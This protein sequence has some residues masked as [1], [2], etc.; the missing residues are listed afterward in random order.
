MTPEEIRA[1]FAEIKEKNSDVVIEAVST[2]EWPSLNGHLYVRSLTLGQREDFLLT[3]QEPDGAG[4]DGKSN[5]KSTIRVH[6]GGHNA[7]L[8]AWTLCNKAGD[9]I[10]SGKTEEVD[11]LQERS[12]AAM[13]R[14]AD[15]SASINGMD[16][17]AL[18]AAKNELPSV[19][20][21]GSNTV[22]R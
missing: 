16:K 4:A 2:P 20:I 11:L 15:K 7:K 13:Q 10:F 22:S 21:S 17:K 3:L 18:E 14:V 12:G 6:Y 1:A 9:L 19:V 8:A 5:G